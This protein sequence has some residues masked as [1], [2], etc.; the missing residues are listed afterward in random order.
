MILAVAGLSMVKKILLVDDQPDQLEMFEI[1]FLE[2]YTD[3]YSII[4]VTSGEECLEYLK[5]NE[6][7]DLILLDIMM[8]GMNGWEVQRR[9]KE[10]NEWRTIPIIFLTARSDSYSQ[11]VGSTVSNDYVTKPVSVHELKKAIDK[12]FRKDLSQE[13]QLT[14]LNKDSLLEVASIGASHAATALSKMVNKYI[15]ISVPKVDI[16]PIEKTIDSLSDRDVSVGIYIKISDEY[17][18]YCLLLMNEKNAFSLID[19]LFDEQ[20]NELD[21]YLSDMYK[22]ALQ[23]I[24]NIMM[25]SFLN[26]VAKLLNITIIPGPPYIAHDEPVAIMDE[27][28]IE[29]G[30]K[31]NDVVLFD[32]DFE[33]NSGKT[34]DIKMFILPEPK[35]IRNILEKIEI[36]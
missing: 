12:V 11:K 17:P 10:N 5:N 4:P 6:L 22:S 36:I 2:H 1:G 16:I 25:C 15:G 14:E 26:S 34:F 29:L 8:P 18:S 7:P 33:C 13:S 28:L 32:I 21:E 3:D 20:P 9:L 30:R 24:G 31:T 23:E 27:L 19:L 35:T